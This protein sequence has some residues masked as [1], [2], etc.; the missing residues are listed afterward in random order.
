MLFY[1]INVVILTLR[2]SDVCRGYRKATPGCNGLK[3][4]NHVE[5]L[6]TIVL[7]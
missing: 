5:Y 3:S 2:F 6:Y 4:L 1:C 7:F